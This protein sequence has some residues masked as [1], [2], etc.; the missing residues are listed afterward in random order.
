MILKNARVSI[1]SAKD[2]P[3]VKSVSLIT[4]NVKAG[5]I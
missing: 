2:L 5:K 1:R 4:E 3:N